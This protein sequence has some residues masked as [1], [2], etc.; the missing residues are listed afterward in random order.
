MRPILSEDEKLL[1]DS[2]QQFINAN[3]PI[4]HFRQLRQSY[5]KTGFS[6][7]L[8]QSMSELG[9]QGLLVSEELGGYGL[10]FCEFAQILEQCG[11]TLCPSPLISNSIIAT[12][13]IVNSGN[14]FLIQ[15]WL[16]GLTTGT[17]CI[18]LAHSEKRSGH[19]HLNIDTTMTK[20]EENYCIEGQKTLVLNAFASDAF[21]VSCRDQDQDELCLFLVS[22]NDEN[23][24]L[25]RQVL[26]D[27]QITALVKFNKVKVS[28]QG[29]I[30]V[31]T[32]AQNASDLLQE[33]L[34]LGTVALC[35]EML[36]GMQAALDLAVDYLCTREQFGRKIGSFQ[37]LQHRA[38]RLYIELEL[39]RVAVRAA[40]CTVDD[41]EE[42][43]QKK[44]KLISLA[45]ACCSDTYL[46]I[47]TEAL[48]FFGGIGMT[49]EHDIGLYLKKARVSEQMFGDASW[50]RERWAR[51]SG[52]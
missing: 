5:S 31:G 1:R 34:D 44:Q 49:D 52:Y 11:K 12:H 6:N 29:K 7:D 28:K 3:A 15:E 10:G 38:A 37:A 32:Q 25:E 27:G 22:A 40:C 24:S 2:A 45:K 33:T 26:I 16:E 47:T 35:S 17:Q 48:Q 8:W 23:I 4:S 39:A 13:L 36:G 21:I 51:L 46:H 19:N 50:H 41:E 20:E 18:G 42:D 43:I 30:G 9:W 14:Q